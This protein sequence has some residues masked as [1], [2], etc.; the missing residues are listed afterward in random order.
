M[1]FVLNNLQLN[2]AKVS[3]GIVIPLGVDAWVRLAPMFGPRYKQ[4]WL[5]VTKPYRR[6]LPHLPKN[7]IRDLRLRAM[8]LGCILDWEGLAFVD[9]DGVTKP[10]GKYTPEKAYKILNRL[11]GF[12][13]EV[14]E[15]A[16]NWS[17]YRG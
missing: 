7:R 10:V 3:E 1:P 9:D 13:Q 17:N 8:A 2:P 15:R 12:V 6:Q 16:K 4:A 5:Q 14:E 11:P